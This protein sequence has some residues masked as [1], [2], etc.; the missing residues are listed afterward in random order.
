MNNINWY[1]LEPTDAW[2]FRDGRPSNLGE[3]QSDLESLFP[4]HAST[5]VGALRAALAREQG[6]NGKDDWCETIKLILGDGFDNLGQLAFRGPFLMK[7]DELLFPAPG[8]LLGN[9]EQESFHPKVFLTP[10][11]E[12]I[13]CDLGRVHLPV[14]KET[15]SPDKKPFKPADSYWVTTA[16]M[17]QILKGSFPKSEEFIHQSQ[18]FQLEA[19]VGIERDEK[20][21]TPKKGALYSPQYIRLKKEVSLVMGIVGLPEQWSLPFYFPLGGESRLA[22]CESLSNSPQFPQVKTGNCNSLILVTSA[23][24]QGEQWYGAGPGDNACQLKSELCGKIKTALFDRPIHI[25]GWDSR[26]KQ[27]RPMESYIPAGAVWWLEE[28]FDFGN[29]QSF[30]LLGDNNNYGYGMALPAIYKQ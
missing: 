11:K 27:P 3:D 4:P 18:L 13:L 22:S 24:F 21:Q 8:H 15:L 7:K 25:G 10:S 19:R 2:F 12:K 30:L 6:W 9:I 28:P 14:S 16:G 17:T 1:K 29:D 20:T 26:T 23:H 5:V